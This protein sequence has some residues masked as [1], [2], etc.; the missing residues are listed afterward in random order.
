MN[1]FFGAKHAQPS[2][3]FWEIFFI[4]EEEF[5]VVL[6]GVLSGSQFA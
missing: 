6:L 2:A 1:E 5:L 4:L 3:S